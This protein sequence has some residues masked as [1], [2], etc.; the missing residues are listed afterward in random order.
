MAGRTSF[1]YHSQEI[2]EFV[3]HSAQHFI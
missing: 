1:L 3:F 2:V